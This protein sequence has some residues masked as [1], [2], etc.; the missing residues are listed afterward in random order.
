M[1]RQESV[2]AVV[3]LRSRDYVISTRLRAGCVYL[4]RRGLDFFGENVNTSIELALAGL[5]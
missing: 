4:L 2:L 1:L 5:D 3:S